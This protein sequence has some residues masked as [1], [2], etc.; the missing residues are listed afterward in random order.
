M[1]YRFT[2]FWLALLALAL[3]LPVSAAQVGE[4]TP[5]AGA[6]SLE[7][8]ALATAAYRDGDLETARVLWLDEL[9]EERDALGANA[10]ARLCYNLGN[11]A[12]RREA[13]LTASAWYTASLRLRPRD[14]DAWANLELARMNAGLDAADRGDLKS[15]VER[16]LG[17]LTPGESRWL[18][19]FGLL[20]LVIALAG[21]ALRGGLAWRAAS[22]A[23]LALALFA[24]LPWLR[25]GLIDGEHPVFVVAASSERGRNEPRAAASGVGALEPGTVLERVDA[26]PGWVEVRFDDGRRGWAREDVIFDLAR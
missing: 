6:E 8:D 22:W 14:A 15:T 23:G 24:A 4:V 17:A 9:R 1:R 20:P 19:L 12:G 11:L 16:L 10:R 3:A 21:E 25:H 18:A 2:R 13:W 26:L 5:T 7:R